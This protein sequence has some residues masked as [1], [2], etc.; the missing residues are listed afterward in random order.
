MIISNESGKLGCFP[1]SPL[2]SSPPPSLSFPSPSSWL[3]LWWREQRWIPGMRERESTDIST[4]SD[5]T[6]NIKTFYKH[7]LKCT[8]PVNHKINVFHYILRGQDWI[9]KWA[10]EKKKEK[11][12]RFYNNKHDG[13]ENDES[14]QGG[15]EIIC[16]SIRSGISFP[17]LIISEKG[18]AKQ[19]DV[20]R[21]LSAHLLLLLLFGNLQSWWVGEGGGLTVGA[22]LHL[23]HLKKREENKKKKI[24][25]MFHM[26]TV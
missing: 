9:V 13:Q 25:N 20:L 7:G 4:T 24:V 15:F 2:P 6:T 17:E 26:F 22:V 8:K 5:V 10:T 21:R 23:R 3:W 18:K 16:K 12:Q 14:L 11:G 1:H 19:A